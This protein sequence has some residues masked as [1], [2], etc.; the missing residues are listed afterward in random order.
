MAEKAGL[1]RIGK[2]GLLI[3][4]TYG[5][6]LILGGIVTTAELPSLSW[7]HKDDRGCPEGCSIC[8]EAC[9]ITAIDETD[10]VDRQRCIRYSMK[11]PMFSYFMKSGAFGHADAA[12]INHLTAVDDHSMYTCVECVAACPIG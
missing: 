9:P 11:S 1:G 3:N 8:R 5:P 6:R 4:A 7:P 12:L 2:N 10:R